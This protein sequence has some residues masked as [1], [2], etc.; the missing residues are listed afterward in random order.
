MDHLMFILIKFPLKIIK[1]TC[2]VKAKYVDF[3]K[4]NQDKAALIIINHQSIFDI[5]LSY[6]K[7][8]HL[9]GYI[10][11]KDLAVPFFNG[12]MTGA[13]SIFID[14][15]DTKDA[16]KGMVKMIENIKQG[17]SMVIFPE[18]TINKTG[19]PSVLQAFK[20]GAFKIAAK[21]KCPIIPVVVANSNSVFEKQ[22]PK[23]ARGTKVIIKCLGEY[24]IADIPDDYKNT[25]A[26]YFQSIMQEELTKLYKDI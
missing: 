19:N 11:K 24:D 22:K 13:H 5:I 25:P 8:K 9:T 15:S 4:I 12:W 26:N 3:D 7:W 21:A 1:I 10:S 20:D 14:R 18:G 17:I 23:V 2:A 16:L 6:P